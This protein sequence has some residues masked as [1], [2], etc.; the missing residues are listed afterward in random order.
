MNGAKTRGGQASNMTHQ[1]NIK[2]PDLGTQPRL[3]FGMANHPKADHKSHELRL[4]RADRNRRQVAHMGAERVT[5][6]Q[7]SNTTLQEKPATFPQ[8]LMMPDLTAVHSQAM[9]Q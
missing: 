1:E 9:T 6:S 7:T 5:T 4:T 3:R 2:I 8:P